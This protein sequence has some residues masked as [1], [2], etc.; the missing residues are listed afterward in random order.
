MSE[1]QLNKIKPTTPVKQGTD[2]RFL[3]QIFS[4]ISHNGFVLIKR[5]G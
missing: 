4:A 1:K 5:H 3:E 2:C